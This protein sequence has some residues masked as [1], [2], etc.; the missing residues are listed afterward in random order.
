M[1]AIAT[2]PAPAAE[3][4]TARRARRVPIFPIAFLGLL[5]LLLVRNR[6]L[7]TAAVD[8]RGDYAANSIIVDQARH[9]ELLV[10]NYSRLGFSHPGPAFF[11]VQAFG[12]WLLADL[13]GA[14]PTEW[15]GQAVAMLALAAAFLAGSLAI[16]RSWFDSAGPA[17]A[18]SAAALGYL[19]FHGHVVASMWMP[20]AY[21]P[22]F[23]LLLAAAA[24][25]AAG[26]GRHLAAL[27]LAGGFLVHGHAEFLFFVPLLAG[28]ALAALWWRHRRGAASITRR[29]GLLFAAVIALFLLPI[30]VN[31]ALHW[32]GEFGRYFGYGGSGGGH[33]PGAAARYVLG[34]WPGGPV[35]G[36]V[37]GAALLGAVPLL[38]RGNPVTRTGPVAIL[39]GTAQFGV[40]AAVGIDD[41]TQAYVGY[42]ALA[43]PLLLMTLAAAVTADRAARW[44]ADRRSPARR[45]LPA[46]V[47]TALAAALLVAARSPQLVAPLD[48]EPTL[49]A[50]VD[51]VRAYTGG[52]PLVLEL[53]HDAW[54][55]MTGLLVGA[56]RRGVRVCV[57]DPRWRFLVTADYLCR[58]AELAGG[59]PATLTA[60]PPP[61][62]PAR[63]LAT[64][65]NATLTASA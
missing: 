26:R 42:F 33:G 54:P 14:V 60:G 3:T 15:N 32:P 62:A 6:S 5:A 34:F 49:P 8:E 9:F 11:Y 36:A 2:A 1:T 7:F 56:Q 25:V 19:A 55:A 53:D 52:R 24:S 22:A 29:D 57:R 50:A 64:L 13:L 63:P 45:L 61:A 44:L 20:F 48:A 39:A 65:I 16:L 12:E 17:L 43:F 35:I 21:A 10:G 28:G 31:L 46:V 59:A 4:S 41:L 47:V 37:V 18:G 58:P 38:G 40:Y 30:A 51:A 27:A 23:L